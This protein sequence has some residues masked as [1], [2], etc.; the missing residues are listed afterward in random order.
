MHN[1][2]VSVVVPTPERYAVHKLIVATRRRTDHDGTAKSR[3]DLGQ[4]LALFEAMI[5]TRQH[6]ALASA[7]TEAWNRG[8]TWRDAIR[9]SL[10]TFGDD[11]RSMANKGLAAGLAELGDDPAKYNLA[12]EPSTT[13]K[14]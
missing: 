13:S 3:K 10:S 2:G 14:G 4:A 6:V 8:E 1:A 12:N 5:R 11:A 7:Y 9:Q